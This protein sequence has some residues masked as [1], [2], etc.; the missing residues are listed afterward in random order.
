[1]LQVLLLVRPPAR[2]LAMVAAVLHLAGRLAPV[3]PA[4]VLAEAAVA[5]EV[6]AMAPVQAGL[7][8]TTL[9]SGPSA[10]GLARVPSNLVPLVPAAPQQA[11]FTGAAQFTQPACYG[12]APQL[13]PVAHAPAVRPSSSTA[14]SSTACL[15]VPSSDA[16]NAAGPDVVALG[17]PH[18]RQRIQH[19]VSHSAA[20]PC[21]VGT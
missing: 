18:P 9:G 15:P 8:S 19:G 13:L 10:C 2:P 5:V 17:P 21:G 20:Q 16:V 7:L 11:L 12:P 6:D 3:V 1:M 4:A 14:S